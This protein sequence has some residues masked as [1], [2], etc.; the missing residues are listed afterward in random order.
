MGREE[1]S[2][3]GICIVISLDNLLLGFSDKD[4]GTGK[5]FEFFNTFMVPNSGEVKQYQKISF[6]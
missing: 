6:L 1:F 4:A 2:L 3:I 5:I